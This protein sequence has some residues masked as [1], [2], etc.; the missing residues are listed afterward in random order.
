M[1]KFVKRIVQKG[2]A[3]SDG[4][5]SIPRQERVARNSGCEQ[6]SDSFEDKFVSHVPLFGRCEKY[7]HSV[8]ATRYV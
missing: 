4:W 5:A 7:I 2:I 8:W 6:I 3:W 1:S